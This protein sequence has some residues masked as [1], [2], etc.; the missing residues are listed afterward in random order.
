MRYVTALE[1][2]TAGA[3]ATSWFD[4]N[5]GLATAFVAALGLIAVIGLAF[6][7]ETRGEPLPSDPTIQHTEKRP[8]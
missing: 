4:G 3:M 5:L 7:K 6:V 2:L 1:P 8:S